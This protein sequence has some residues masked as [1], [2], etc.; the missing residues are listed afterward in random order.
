MA[1][2]FYDKQADIERLKHDDERLDQA[3]L[4][5]ERA[6]SPETETVRPLHTPPNVR[7]TRH[8]IAPAMMPCSGRIPI[9]IMALGS[10]ES[11]SNVS[12]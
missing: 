4:S 9:A 3:K 8:A 10:S 11:R 2:L 7:P 6:E 12:A 1:E 5:F